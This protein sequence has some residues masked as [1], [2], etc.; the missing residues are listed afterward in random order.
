VDGLNEPNALYKHLENYCRREGTAHQSDALPPVVQIQLVGTLAFDAGSLD[1]T[2]MEEI[3]RTHFQT[4]FVRI[5]NHTN[6]QDY[7]PDGGDIDGRDPSTWHELERRIFED[8]VSRDNRYLATKEQ[9]S[10][11]LA[12]LKQMALQKDDPAL[13]AQFLREKR[14]NCWEYS[15][16]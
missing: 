3:V 2:Y 5:D 9:W 4:L 11:V 16:I 12:D 15:M 14:Q 13:I 10:V 1:Q 6:E 7:I 8:L